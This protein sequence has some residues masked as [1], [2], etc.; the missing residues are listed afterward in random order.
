MGNVYVQ[1]REEEHAANALK[2]LSGRFYAGKF[3]LTF[4][5]LFG[6]CLALVFVF[7]FISDYVHF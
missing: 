4:V 2:N 6:L 5:I 3:I 1:F 7:T